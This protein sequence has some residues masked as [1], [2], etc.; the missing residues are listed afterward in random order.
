MSDRHV[1]QKNFNELLENYRSEV[2]PIALEDWATLSEV[3]KA[4]IQRMNNFFC[5]LHFITELADSEEAVLKQWE[6]TVLEPHVGNWSLPEN[7]GYQ[8]SESGTQRL[9]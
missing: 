5:G 7:R 4:Q 6:S 8:S 3:E 1:V 9:I 2:L